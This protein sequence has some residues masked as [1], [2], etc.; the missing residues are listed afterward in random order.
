[1]GIFKFILICMIATR[2][3]EGYRRISDSNIT[4]LAEVESSSISA[5]SNLIVDWISNAI[6]YITELLD[7]KVRSVRFIASLYTN[8]NLTLLKNFMNLALRIGHWL[9]DIIPNSTGGG[10]QTF[11]SFL[12]PELNQSRED[13]ENNNDGHSL[14]SDSTDDSSDLNEIDDTN[15][16]LYRDR[17]G[18]QMLNLETLINARSRNR[19]F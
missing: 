14:T 3:A 12:F 10:A 11:L 6:Q 8:E 5:I 4:D 19:N 7:L 16:N 1:M 15:E 17:Y 18:K 2:F 13:A 9:Y